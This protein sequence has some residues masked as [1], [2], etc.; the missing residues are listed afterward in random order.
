MAGEILRLHPQTVVFTPDTA[1]PV[2][3]A[4]GQIQ[5]PIGAE[6]HPSGEVSGGLPRVGHKDVTDIGERRALE[7]SACQGERIATLPPLWVGEIDES[8][9]RE[10]RMD[11]DRVEAI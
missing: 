3:I 1:Q 10:L 6:Q 11:G 4:N 2:A 7:T 5:C 8:V 9:L